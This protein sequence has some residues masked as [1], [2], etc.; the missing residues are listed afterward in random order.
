MHPKESDPPRRRD[1]SKVPI[2]RKLL[3]GYSIATHARMLAA[4]ETQSSC[5]G[6]LCSGDDRSWQCLN[7]SAEAHR[8]AV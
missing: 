4:L 2:T 8:S 7:G 6:W 1:G 3:D 5:R